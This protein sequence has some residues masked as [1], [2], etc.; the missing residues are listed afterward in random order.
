M[1]DKESVTGVEA[2]KLLQ[3]IV[4]DNLYGQTHNTGEERRKGKESRGEE[5]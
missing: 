3:K 1:S 2:F 5:C 4:D